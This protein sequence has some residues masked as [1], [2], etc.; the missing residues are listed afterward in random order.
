MFHGSRAEAGQATENIVYDVHEK[1]EEPE[2]PKRGRP[3]F[4]QQS[5]KGPFKP[6]PSGNSWSRLNWLLRSR[7][8]DLHARML[9]GEISVYA[10][11]RIAGFVKETM[12]IRLDDPWLIAWRVSERLDTVPFLAFAEEVATIA[13]ERRKEEREPV[14]AELE[15]SDGF[16]SRTVSIPRQP[17]A[18]ARRLRGLLSAE[19]REALAHSLL[20]G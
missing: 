1:P 9:A 4:W 20:D 8:P 11:S 15:Q 12:S 13:E 7:R 6:R 16:Q 5:E 19:E 14:E 18:M 17:E 3:P 10:A 2:K